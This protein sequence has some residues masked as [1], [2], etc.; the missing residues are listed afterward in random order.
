MIFST[1]QENFK[2]SLQN[3]VH[4]AGRN[5]NLP[6][7]NNILIAVEKSEIKLIT[8]NLEL[9]IISTLRGKIEKEGSFTVEAGILNEYISILPNKKIQIEKKEQTME[10]V[11]D[12]YKTVIKG[13][14]AEEFPLIPKIDKGQE[15]AVKNTDLK[16]ALSQVIF[17]VSTSENRIEMSGV[18]FNF[19]NNNI[20]TMAATDSYRLAEKQIKIKANIKEEKQ[21]IIP[22]KTIQ[23]L[24][25]IVSNTKSTNIENDG[26]IKIYLSE[27]QILFEFNNVEIISRLIDGQ[28][29]DYKKIIP[30]EFLTQTVINKEELLRA[31]KAAAIFS[32]TGTNEI[33]LDFLCD[34]KKIIIYS[35]SNKIG[36]NTT[37][38]NCEVKGGDSGVVLNYRYLLD[39]INNINSEN[40]EIQITTG[41]SLCVLKPEK[42]KDYLYIIMPIKQ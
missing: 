3:V 11:C 36:E 8:T 17:S 30:N 39:G 1:L 26:E 33:N 22:A 19:N 10:I 40:I 20:L 32:K 4:I 34:T 27:N 38:L 24:L 13:Q 6:I 2:N 12:N 41:S 7:L 29:P 31:V 9:G 21:I 37:T 15:F 25:R 35:Q 5:N 16:D 42:N 23:E 28:Y 14:D 18:L